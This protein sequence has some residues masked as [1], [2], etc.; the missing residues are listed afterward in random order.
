ML[1]SLLRFWPRDPWLRGGVGTLV[2][3]LLGG[4]VFGG[5]LLATRSHLPY[6]SDFFHMALLGYVFCI[7]SAVAMGMI[8]IGVGALRIWMKRDSSL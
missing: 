4:L 6:A 2:S 5:M 8:C 3:T 7:V 1:R